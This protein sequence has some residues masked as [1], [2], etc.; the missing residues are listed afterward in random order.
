M[1]TLVTDRS[2]FYRVK[3]G[4][5]AREI[6]SVFEIPVNRPAF[7]GAILEIGDY[8]YTSY[9][10]DLGESYESIAEKFGVDAE[11]LK[12]VNGKKPIYPTRK[13]FVPY[14]QPR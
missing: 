9:I 6:E 1:F 4:Q 7:S 2:K 3:R 14:K 13:I 10:A 8:F 5:N 12:E 11:I